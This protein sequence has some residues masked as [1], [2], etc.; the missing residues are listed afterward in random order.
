MLLL[1]RAQIHPTT[2]LPLMPSL[3]NHE[4]H[5]LV[6][7]RDSPG[8]TEQAAVAAG[9]PVGVCRGMQEMPTYTCS[10]CCA[11]VVLNPLRTR[12]REY[13]PKCDHYI[14]DKCA[15]IRVAKGGDYCK[16]YKQFIDEVQ[17]AEA[18]KAGGGGIIIP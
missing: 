3:R 4:G 1:T 12:P 7:H 9:M 17:N 16:T 10:H 5:L 11:V 18:G 15:A 14:C 2:H 13:C 6:D 8:I